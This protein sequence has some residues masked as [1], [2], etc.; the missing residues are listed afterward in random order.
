MPSLLKPLRFRFTDPQDIADYGDRY[1]IY[2]ESAITSQR[3]R[4]LMAL[5]QEMGL[6]IAD[7]MNGVRAS[8]AVGDMA[9]SWLAMKLDPDTGDKAPAFDDYNPI[10]MMIV[11][12]AVPAEELEP[13]KEEATSGERVEMEPGGSPDMPAS[14][15]AVLPDE[16]PSA[17]ISRTDTVS[18]VT[19]PVTESATS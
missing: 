1:W 9:G 15:P 7:V 8:S 13:G 6:P 10:V 16:S 5:E 19:M 18:L 14:A 4:T 2:D 17:A 11:W 12:S 3:A